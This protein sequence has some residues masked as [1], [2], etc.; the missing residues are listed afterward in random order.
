MHARQVVAVARGS[1]EWLV[2]FRVHEYQESYFCCGVGWSR[3]CIPNPFTG[4]ANNRHCA[5]DLNED[6]SNIKNEARTVAKFCLQ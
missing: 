1:S 4:V 6:I 3:A 2:E 5:K